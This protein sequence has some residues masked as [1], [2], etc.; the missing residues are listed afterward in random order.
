MAPVVTVK[1]VRDHL[2]SPPWS[3]EQEAAC[4]VLI[5]ARQT[6]LARWFG[7]PIDPVNRIE[8]VRVLDSGLIATTWP[9]H[10]VFSVG[11]LAVAGPGALLWEPL[12]A[13]YVWR[14]EGWIAAPE[15]G[16][17]TGYATR[18]YSILTGDPGGIWVA[19]SYAGGWGPA[20]DITGALIEKVGAAMLNRHDDTVT[21]RR[22]DAEEPPPVNEEWTDRELMML[23]S[24][25]RWRGGH[26][27]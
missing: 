3:A 25:R 24:R 4:A 5:A 9:V 17:A 2:S 15:P 14:D 1:Q 27:R 19:V 10:R 18:A 7:A 8:T 12:P 23:R 21:A 22:L 16:P 6:G 11:G 13:P 20:P 26:C